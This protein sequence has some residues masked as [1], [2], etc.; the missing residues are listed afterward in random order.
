MKNI[1]RVLSLAILGAIS[2]TSL[3]AQEQTERDILYDKFK[4]CYK[5][6]AD[7]AKI[8]A[9]IATGN[10][11]VQKHGSEE[12]YQ[13][14]IDWVKKKIV[15]LQDTKTEN[16]RAALFAAFD[17]SFKARKKEDD[18]NLKTQK[19]T[20]IFNSGKNLLSSNL[21]SD[22]KKFDVMIILATVGFAATS[23]NK[24]DNFNADT[25][26]YSKMIIEK[27]GKGEKPASG[28]NW[29]PGTSDY[30][31]NTKEN[32]LA[33]MN[34]NIGFILYQRQQKTDEAM[35]YLY[36]GVQF[37]S[38]EIATKIAPYDFIGN[39]YAERFNK[40]IDEYDVLKKGSNGVDTE[41][42]NKKI[43]EI[44]AIAE[45]GAD[46]FSRAYK[47]AN[48]NPTNAKYA[49]L[50]KDRVTALYKKRFGDKAATPAA[51]NAYM[52]GVTA[53]PFVDPM[54]PIVPV[55]EATPTTAPTTTPTTKPT[56]TPTTTP[57]TKPTTTPATKPAT[58]PA[59]KPT[60]TKPAAKPAA[61]P[62]GTR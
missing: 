25:I 52:A 48:V 11:L 39:W 14:V 59:A 34:Y 43:G 33:Y 10:E 53:K 24:I 9:C 32:L 12:D 38:S 6:T 55:V 18:T 60:A 31:Y 13:N 50:L 20:E 61:K 47:I 44:K 1:L 51:V 35:P 2:V 4:G 62:K 57:T 41:E 28:D 8:T 22:P 26:N 15:I 37:T 56:T 17:N 54:S 46:A 7:N 3:I 5:E 30:K 58:K 49:T 42:T 19:L 29:G 16:E 45:R 40:A 36:K 27:V 21:V 23:D